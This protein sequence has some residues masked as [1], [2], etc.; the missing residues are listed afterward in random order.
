MAPEVIKEGATY[1]TK[2]CDILEMM[3]DYVQKNFSLFINKLR[4]ISGLW[5]LL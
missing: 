5:E 4:R 1:D 3:C 2:V